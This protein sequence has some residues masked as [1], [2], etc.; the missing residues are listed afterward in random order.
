MKDKSLNISKVSLLSTITP[1]LNQFEIEW[2][3]KPL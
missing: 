2:S 3:R 1:R